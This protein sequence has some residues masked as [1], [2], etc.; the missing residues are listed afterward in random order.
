MILGV[1]LDVEGTTTPVEFVTGTLFPFARRRLREFLDAHADDRVLAPDLALLRLE[2]VAERSRG[3]SPPPVEDLAQFV[4]WLM[5][6]D[7]KSTGLKA[8]Q[9]RIWEEGYRSGELR[10]V[11][12]DDVPPALARWRRAGRRIAIYSSGSIQAQRLLFGNTG[13]GDLTP[14]IAAYFDTTSGPKKEPSSYRRIAEAMDLAPESM[15]FIS[16]VR[17][18]LD[19]AFRAGLKT[20]LSLR[21]G[22]EPCNPGPHPSIRSFAEALP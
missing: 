10:S 14:Q 1:L 8:L 16:D 20:L 22:N 6:H 19:A 4:G 18:E 12:Y 7:R 11:V 17:A 3:Q 21:P 13:S 5:D 9:G 2:H 15:L